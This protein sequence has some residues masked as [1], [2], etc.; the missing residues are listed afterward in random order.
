[1]KFKIGIVLVLVMLLVMPITARATTTIRVDGIECKVTH[2]FIDDFESGVQSWRF[3]DVEGEST[4]T[5]WSTV[6]EDGNTVLRGMDHNWA[7]LQEKEWANYTFK[8]K[9][10]I[11]QGTIHFN[12]RREGSNRYFIGVRSD[13]LYVQKQISKNFYDLTTSKY[14]SLDEGWHT[15]E[16]RGYDNIL[17]IY[18]DDELLI[19]YK[20]TESP[21]LSGGVA[22]ETLDNSEFLIDDVEIKVIAEKTPAA[23]IISNLMINPAKVAIG[24]PVTIAV[25]VTNVGELEGTYKAILII[26]DVRIETKDVTV[27]GGATETV[28]FS[29]VTKDAIGAYAVDVGGQTKTLRVLKTAAFVVSNLVI[30]SAEVETGKPVVITIDVTNTGEAKDIYPVTLSIDGAEIETVPISVAGGGTETVSF[31]VIR[32][33]IGTYSVDVDG[34][35]GSFTVTEQKPGLSGFEAVFAIAGLLAVAYLIGRKE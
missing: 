24:K 1:M 6:V 2:Y 35:T 18:I 23:F 21:I 3:Y 14:L 5:A 19:E 16:I 26:D 15:F 31:T 27:A 33:E 10:K 22:F 32:D 29:P 17:N 4:T 7:D 11:I 9:F 34:Q 8:A 25:D 20:D 13:Q 30:K 12:Y 28:T